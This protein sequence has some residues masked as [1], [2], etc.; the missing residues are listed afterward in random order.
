MTTH[1]PRYY[2]KKLVTQGK[3]LGKKALSYFGRNYAIHASVVLA[4][5]FFLLSP[6]VLFTVSPFTDPANGNGCNLIEV[7]WNR[8][9]TCKV[10]LMAVAI[11]SVLFGLLTYMVLTAFFK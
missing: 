9:A 7:P 11:H 6:G 3:N 2:G 1:N 4:F 5:L 8:T 10:D